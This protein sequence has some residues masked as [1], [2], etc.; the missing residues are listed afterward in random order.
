ME[1]KCVFGSRGF[2]LKIALRLSMGSFRYLFSDLWKRILSVVVSLT[3]NSYGV[4]WI[5]RQSKGFCRFSV[6]WSEFLRIFLVNL[7][8][9]KDFV[10]QKS[11]LIAALSIFLQLFLDFSM[12]IE[13]LAN[14]L[15][16]FGSW[17]D[18]E[19]FEQKTHIKL[20]F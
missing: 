19:Q 18:F 13:K 10:T 1:K 7:E 17:V 14:L 5:Y 16:F 2:D 6:I 4:T 15:E 20:K 12:K 9:F 8:R 11:I 3:Q